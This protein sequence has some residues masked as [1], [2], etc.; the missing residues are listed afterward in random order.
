VPEYASRCEWCG[1]RFADGYS[2]DVVEAESEQLNGR[3]IVA[4]LGLGGLLLAL[5]IYFAMIF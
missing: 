1:H 2:V 4:F 3:T 5:A